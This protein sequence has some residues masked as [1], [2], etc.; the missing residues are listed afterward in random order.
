MNSDKFKLRKIFA[1]SFAFSIMAGSC[2]NAVDQT[3][4]NKPTVS[5]SEP[6]NIEKKLRHHERVLGKIV[7]GEVVDAMV[8]GTCAFLGGNLAYNIT[9]DVYKFIK[10]SQ[11]IEDC[12]ISKLSGSSIC[13]VGGKIAIAFSSAEEITDD[14]FKSNNF[15]NTIAK[16]NSSNLYDGNKKQFLNSVTKIRKAC[17]NE[18]NQDELLNVKY[19]DTENLNHG[20]LVRNIFYYMDKKSKQ[21]KAKLQ[22]TTDTL[23]RFEDFDY[24][25]KIKDANA[26]NTLNE[27]MQAII[28]GSV[29]ESGFNFGTIN[30]SNIEIFASNSKNNN[31]LKQEIK[32]IDGKNGFKFYQV[33]NE[34]LVL[35]QQTVSG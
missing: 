3:I 18:I 30:D 23:F 29:S 32:K 35:I 13:V 6:S 28:D 21:N 27:N 5:V 2:S 1:T 31:N 19:R 17:V 14:S 22:F 7:A 25:F 34:N 12:K 24:S 8:L 33:P 15:E 10:R 26:I 9:K 11:T 20:P 16:V 4:E